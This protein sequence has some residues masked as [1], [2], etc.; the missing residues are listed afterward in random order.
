M[1]LAR[2]FANLGHEVTILAMNTSKHYIDPSSAGEALR[3][4]GIRAIPVYVDTDIRPVRM[5]WNYLFSGLPYNAERF[6]SKAFDEK[7]REVLSS[8]TFDVIQLEGLYLAPYLATIR[9]YS[10][11]KVAMRA[12]N[13]EH[14]IWA[15]ACHREHGLRRFYIK[16]LASRI[17]KMEVGSLNEFDAMIPITKRDGSVL[18]ELGCRLPMH[19]VPT[20]VDAEKFQYG[21]DEMEFPS[22]FHIGALDWIPNQEGLFWF[23][24][25]VWDKVLEEF[26]QVKF[27]IAG[28]NA[29]YRIRNL[30]Y[31]NLEFLGEVDDA[32]AFMRSKAVMVVPVLSGSGMR[33]KIIEG[34]AT[35][36]AIVTTAIGTEGISTTDGKNILIA[37]NPVPFADAVRALLRDLPYYKKIGTEA[38]EFIVREYDNRIITLSLI[39]FYQKMIS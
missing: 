9:K 32:Y 27:Y 25:N 11:A 14:E 10:T 36:R 23:L 30:T 8:E 31:P 26:P 13:I 24:D 18:K 3:N 21:F 6:I 1:G 35:A 34:M 16:N 28:R 33:I 19:V 22:V 5:A 12:H 7:I 2:S 15:R 29:P 38:R 37:D 39:N 17:R 20:G 4:S